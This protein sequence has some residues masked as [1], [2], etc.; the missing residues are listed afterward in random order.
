MLEKLGRDQILSQ[1]TTDEPRQ[2]EL[3]T[4]IGTKVVNAVPMTNLGFEEEKR[5]YQ[6]CKNKVEDYKAG[7]IITIRGEGCRSVTS[8]EPWS[9]GYKVIYEDGY[10]SWSPKEVFERC[11]REITLNEKGLIR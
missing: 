2:P 11:Y 1:A 4:Y 3:K 7:E 6:I 5:L 9:E 8:C 10:I